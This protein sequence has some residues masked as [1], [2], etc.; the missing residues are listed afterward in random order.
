MSYIR[1]LM[2]FVC[3]FGFLTSSSTSRLYRGRALRQSVWQF[4]VLPHMRQSWETMTSVS[5]C[6]IITDTDPTSRERAVTAA[7]ETG[8]S[9]PE[10]ARST[11]WAILPSINENIMD[12]KEV[13]QRSNGNGWIQKIPTQNHQEKIK[14]KFLGKCKISLRAKK[15][16]GGGGSKVPLKVFF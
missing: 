4:Y 5:A 8:T 1:R 16:G 10:V 3:L 2:R 7:I 6:H 12:W 15:K 9:S 14:Y 11:D 13:K